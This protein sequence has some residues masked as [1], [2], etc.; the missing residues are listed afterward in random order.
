MTDKR[1]LRKLKE[2]GVIKC[3][4]HHYSPFT[5]SVNVNI[6]EDMI[7]FM[8]KPEKSMRNPN[9]FIV[10][11]IPKD[12]KSFESLIPENIKK[13]KDYSYT[14]ITL[15]LSEVEEKFESIKLI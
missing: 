4:T 6:P 14:Y 1:E 15:E 11:I 10:D 3:F 2:S 13:H 12:K 9:E 5:G 7:F 8:N